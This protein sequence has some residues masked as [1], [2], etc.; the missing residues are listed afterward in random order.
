MAS[1]AGLSH[2]VYEQRIRVF[3]IAIGSLFTLVG[4]GISPRGRNVISRGPQASERMDQRRQRRRWGCEPPQEPPPQQ[5]LNLL[6][7]WCRTGHNDGHRAGEGRSEVVENVS[8]DPNVRTRFLVADAAGKTLGCL[9][10]T[11]N[12]KVSGAAVG[13]SHMVPCDRG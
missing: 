8:S 2:Q 4:V 11:F 13:V 12:L 6:G 3:R 1:R 10:L 7:S 9:S 5:R